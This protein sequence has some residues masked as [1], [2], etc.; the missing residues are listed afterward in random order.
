MRQA[1]R[2][3]VL[4]FVGIALCGDASAQV[5]GTITGTARDASGGVL[6]GVT[7][8]VSS[9]ALIEKVRT[10]VTDGSGLYRIVNLPP[11]TYTV[12]F[13]LTGFNT[14]RREGVNVSPNFTATID[15]DLRVGNLQETVTVTGESPVVDVQSAAATRSIT[16]EVFREIPSS[17]SWVQM[18]SLVP[19]VRAT[20]Q[21]VGG[22]A[23]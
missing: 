6:P 1:L 23:G 9:P 15:G 14:S 5:L 21:D 16:A 3:A 17:G 13:T 11:G 10:A 12:V 18:A 2:A 22:I 7:V 8:E 20:V 4:V 19:A